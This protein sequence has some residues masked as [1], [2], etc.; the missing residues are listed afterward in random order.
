[1]KRKNSLNLMTKILVLV[2]LFIYLPFI[3]ALFVFV[4]FLCCSSEQGLTVVI[5]AVID[6]VGSTFNICNWLDMFYFETRCF[7]SITVRYDG[8][9]FV[10]NFSTMKNSLGAV[11]RTSAQLTN[12]V[13]RRTAGL[14]LTQLSELRLGEFSIRSQRFYEIKFC[15]LI[16][17]KCAPSEILYGF[18]KFIIVVW[19]SAYWISGTRNP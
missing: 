5:L 14:G 12:Q 16:K 10:E 17:V 19:Y 6:A 1:M 11:S 9:K 2:F 15:I 4:R 3:F 7:S 13:R 8:G 18:P